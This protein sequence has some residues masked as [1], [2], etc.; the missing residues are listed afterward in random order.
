MKCINCTR[1]EYNNRTEL[2]KDRT[3]EALILLKRAWGS[4]VGALNTSDASDTSDGMSVMYCKGGSDYGWDASNHEWEPESELHR[5]LDGYFT[6]D[7]TRDTVPKILKFCLGASFQYPDL[8][9]FSETT[10][11]SHPNEDAIQTMIHEYV[12]A[13]MTTHLKVGAWQAFRRSKKSLI[14]SPEIVVGVR[15]CLQGECGNYR[16]QLLQKDKKWLMYA[17][18]KLCD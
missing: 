14:L 8:S 12:K 17:E 2:N 16:P 5:I 11:Y 3:D 13:Q 10:N 1:E 18:Y 9:E 15:E 4:L 6:R 7:T